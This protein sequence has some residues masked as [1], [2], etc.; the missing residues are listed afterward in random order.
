MAYVRLDPACIRC[1]LDKHLDAAPETVS[2]EERV[3]FMQRVLALIA[4]APLSE[5]APVLVSRIQK[6]EKDMFGIEKDYSEEKRVF[7]D[8]MLG[9][10]AEVWQRIEQAKDPLYTAVQFAMIGNYIDFG[11]MDSVDEK[12][13]MELLDNSSQ[14]APQ[15]EAFGAFV[16]DVLSAGKLAYLTDNCGEI[17]MDKLLLRQIHR[18]NPH[19]KLTVIVRG[20]PVLN[21]A[22]VEDA[23]YAGI[24]EHAQ[25]IGNGSGIAGTSLGEI[26]QEARAVIDDADMLIAKGQANFETLRHCGRNAYYIVLC[27]CDLFAKRFCVPRFQGMLLTDAQS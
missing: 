24:D 20:E 10:E 27:K 22:T 25:V 8:L 17:V 6:L 11:A 13:L 5:G 12:K 7:N 21:D 2:Q 16:K 1:L 18:M 9:L 19:A 23:L 26:S 15:E 14:F 3:V 4:E